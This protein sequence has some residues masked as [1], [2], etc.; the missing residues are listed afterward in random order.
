MPNDDKV[1]EKIAPIADKCQSEAGSAAA[2][3]QSPYTVALLIF[4][5][6]GNLG[7]DATL[8][9]MLK[10]V[11]RLRS[12]ARV[13]CI[14]GNPDEVTELFDI[15]AVS[16]WWPSPESGAY[17]IA[18][19]LTLR[20]LNHAR[21]W[22]RTLSFVGGLDAIIIP[23][24]GVLDDYG[25][26][27]FGWPYRLLMWCAAAK[28]CRVPVA[29][30]SSGAGPITGYGNKKL[31]LSAA[32]LASYR[33]YRDDVS[34]AFM[35]ENGFHDGSETVFPD[36]VLGL[37]LEEVDVSGP[38]SRQAAA[39]S[40]KVIGIGINDY[41]GWSSDRVSGLGIHRRYVSST[42]QLISKLHDNGH[43]VQ[44][45]VYT[46]DAPLVDE[47]LEE[48]RASGMETDE[49]WIEV[50]IARTLWQHASDIAETDMVVAA[51]Y[52]TV[53]TALMLSRPTVGLSYADK[54]EAVMADFGVEDY[55]RHIEAFDADWAIAR[56]Q[57]YSASYDDV[58]AG[59]AGALVSPRARLAE[60]EGQ[61]ATQI[62]SN[63]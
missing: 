48:L 35:R 24:T 21:A 7:N 50:R 27:S 63:K 54:F 34:N 2:V 32:R 16:L 49:S 11:R 56:L 33:S 14:C 41:Y 39:G 28:L 4:G 20:Q 58:R 19:R 10:A 37:P 8:E 60:Q 29:F 38:P 55:C 45:L 62:L 40:G 26:T 13:V 17:K 59:L 52:H 18:N 12:G 30:V 42:V 15:P 1:L 23:G 5:G 43:K 44:L 25:E 46:E 31:M 53:V 6:I 47:L 61:L 22:Y 36:L 3:T 51:R 57:E 9:A